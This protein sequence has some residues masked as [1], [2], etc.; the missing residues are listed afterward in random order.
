MNITSTLFFKITFEFTKK[1]FLLV[2]RSK[3]NFYAALLMPIFVC[4]AIFY[5]QHLI[6]STKKLTMTPNP[7][8]VIIQSV[9]KCSKPVDCISIGYFVIGEKE[10]WI[11][12]VMKKVAENSNLEFNKDVKLLAEGSPS[13]FSDYIEK[14][15]NMTQIAIIFCT[16]KWEIAYNNFGTNIPCSFEQIIDK[17]MIFYSIHYNMTLGFEIPYFFKLNAPY[18][19]NPVAVSLKKLIDESIIQHFT[20]KDFKLKARTVSYPTT[21]NKFLKDYDFISNFG[22]FFFYIPFAVILKVY[23]PCTDFRNDQ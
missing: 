14:N 10:D 7:T 11:E 15:R 3:R 19:L 17:K 20:N 8:P 23:F 2:R 9:P 6:E 21:E 4:L 5:I 22:C 12:N 18:P 13:D 16:S 1:N